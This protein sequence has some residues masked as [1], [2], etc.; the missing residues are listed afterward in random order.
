MEYYIIET[1]VEIKS[2]L[3]EDFEQNFYVLGTNS[4]LFDSILKLKTV[5]AVQMPYEY[6]I[7]FNDIKDL[8]KQI[9]EIERKIFVWIGTYIKNHIIDIEC[10]LKQYPEQMD[11]DYFIQEKDKCN[12][13]LCKWGL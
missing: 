2:E 11:I 7:C 13:F 12:H 1:T 6:Q 9:E 8:P 3:L 5:S 10:D 4:P